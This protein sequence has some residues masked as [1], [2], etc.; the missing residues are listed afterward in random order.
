M[1]VHLTIKTKKKVVFVMTNGHH[2]ISM[3]TKNAQENNKFYTHVLGLRRVNYT[4]NQDSPNMY[5]LFYG[6]K[7]GAPGTELTFF[8]IPMAGRT[9]R[10]TNAISRIGLF[11]STYQSLEYWE[12]R[13][14]AKGI[15]TDSIGIYAGRAALQ[16]EDHEGLQFILLNHKNDEIPSTWQAWDGSDVPVEHRILGMGPIE[17]TVRYPEKTIE[18]LKEVFGYEVIERKESYIK[19]QTA[20]GKEFSEIVIIQKDGQVERAGRGSIHH[21]AF[22]AKDEKQLLLWNE[23]LESLGY[24]TSGKVDR[25]YFQSVYV[26]DQNNILFEIATDEPGFTIT[27]LEN[28]LGQSLHLPPKLASKREEIE[29]L[30]KPIE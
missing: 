7:T 17:I 15:E 25:H 19:I 23:K 3:I 5:H 22:R 30:L 14:T 27:G 6:D 13:L 20:I 26:R 18:L 11:V 21:L 28:N 12:E 8:E 16:F 10:G 2:H 4:V 9:Q 24:I 29:A 1:D